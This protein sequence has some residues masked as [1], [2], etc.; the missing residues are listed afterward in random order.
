MAL[1][2]TVLFFSLLICATSYGRSKLPEL[3][4]K[5]AS[6]NLRFLSDDGKST[7]YRRRSGSL[8]HGTNY[9]VKEVLKGT[10]GTN[11]TVKGTPAKKK[12]V[13]VKNPRYHTYLSPRD[14]Q[15]IYTLDYHGSTPTSMGKGIAPRLHLDDRWLSYYSPYRKTIVVKNIAKPAIRYAVK[16]SRGPNPFFIPEVVMRDKDTVI[17]TDIGSR[18]IPKVIS[19][20][21]NTKKRET[22]Y[23]TPS[24][25]KK[26]ELCIKKD[27]LLVGEFGLDPVEPHSMLASIS[28]KGLDFSKRSVFYKSDLPDRGNMVCTLPGDEVYFVKNLTGKDKKERF[29]AVSVDPKSKK[30][31]TLSD[32]FHATQIIDMDGKLLLPYQGKYYVLV[33]TSDTTKFDTLKKKES[34]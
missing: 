33:G 16:I 28:L 1:S 3:V 6:N 9:T 15:Q 30:T 21:K 4:T 13:V 17:F 24:P 31:T 19:Y 10:L 14:P 20:D 18:G 27:I 34:P 25:N 7:Y 29:E 8:L 23:K 2:K 11:Y 22:L 26:I 12:L 32:V 5:Q